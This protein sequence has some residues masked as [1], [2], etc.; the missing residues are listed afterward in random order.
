MVWF[1]TILQYKSIQRS[2]DISRSRVTTHGR[3]PGRIVDLICRAQVQ[4]V[5]MICTL[6]GVKSQK[7]KI[8][9]R[10]TLLVTGGTNPFSLIRS[11]G[12]PTFVHELPVRSPRLCRCCISNKTSSKA[13]TVAS[14]STFLPENEHRE[15]AKYRWWTYRRVGYRTFMV[16]LVTYVFPC[17]FVRP[18]P[19]SA[20]LPKEMGDRLLFLLANLVVR[21][22]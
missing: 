21:I 2:R 18:L 15:I 22:A 3:Q 10:D 13:A 20:D 4:I 6:I 14:S 11:P 17:C 1:N 16:H 5:Q 8:I 7:N 9:V 12:A 19:L